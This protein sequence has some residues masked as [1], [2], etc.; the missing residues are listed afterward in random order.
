MTKRKRISSGL[1]RM[2]AFENVEGA[3]AGIVEHAFEWE[4]FTQKYCAVD[5]QLVHTTGG[6]MSVTID[7]VGDNPDEYTFNV[8]QNS[9]LHFAVYDRVEFLYQEAK[10]C[11]EDLL[12]RYDLSEDGFINFSDPNSI[13]EV[14]ALYHNAILAVNRFVGQTEDALRT[15]YGK[16]ADEVRGWVEEKRALLGEVLSFGFCLEERNHIEH[17]M[18]PL[19]VIDLN[20][21][22]M[23][24]GIGINLDSDYSHYD[25]RKPQGAYQKLRNGFVESRRAEGLRPFLSIAGMLDSIQGCTLTLYIHAI[26]VIGET[27]SQALQDARDLGVELQSNGLL[28]LRCGQSEKAL[29]QPPRRVL[30]WYRDGAIQRFQSRFDYVF[31]ACENLDE[32]RGSTV[33]YLV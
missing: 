11:I 20:P 1:G 21:C 33:L 19:A 17:G 32:L 30:R 31:E 9:G 8:L 7:S 12:R 26:G 10:Y 3:N 29:H 24:A 22:S 25:R 28:L 5:Y 14:N 4:W 23:Q 15:L 16:D 2:E 18:K 27:Y 13:I 6:G